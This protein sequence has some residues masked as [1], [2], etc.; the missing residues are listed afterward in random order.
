M[1]DLGVMLIQETVLDLLLYPWSQQDQ[2]M[3]DEPLPQ[4]MY[5][6]GLVG[7][8]IHSPGLRWRRQSARAA[9]AQ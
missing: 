9:P 3:L 2:A 7:G 1:A 4:P 6:G 8:C 5:P